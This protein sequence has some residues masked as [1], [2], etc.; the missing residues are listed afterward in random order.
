MT[1]VQTCALPISIKFKPEEAM[2]VVE[3]I[4]VQVGRTGILTPVAKLSSV[5]VGG[6]DISRATLHNLDEIRRKDVRIG[7][8]VVVRRAGDVIPEV[9]NP[10]ISKRKGNEIGRASCRERV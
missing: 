6:V 3:D 10:V 9:V 1:G 4:S 8:T 2:T 7:D 5:N